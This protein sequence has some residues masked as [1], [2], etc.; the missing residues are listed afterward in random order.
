MSATPTEKRA[1]AVLSHAPGPAQ[2]VAEAGRNPARAAVGGLLCRFRRGFWPV[3]AE[4]TVLSW[5]RH[6]SM[7][8]LASRTEYGGMA[9]A[10]QIIP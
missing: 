3:P 8:I 5:A 4:W 2:L 1:D 9:G 7:T 6:C 10:P